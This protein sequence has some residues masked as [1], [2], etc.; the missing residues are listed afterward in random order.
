VSHKTSEFDCPQRLLPGDIVEACI[1]QRY[2]RFIVHNVERD[3]HN[4][5]FQTVEA[6]AAGLGSVRFRWF[7]GHYRTGTGH[8]L[9]FYYVSRPSTIFVQCC[10]HPEYP[11]L[12]TEF[13]PKCNNCGATLKRNDP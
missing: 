4:E 1:R 11:A 13:E 9:T 3:P 2:Y 12:M 8:G 6:S 7:G 5:L 10:R